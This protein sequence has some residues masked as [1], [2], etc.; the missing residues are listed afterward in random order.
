M[1]KELSGEG[2]HGTDERDEEEQRLRPE[3][4][5]HSSPFDEPASLT[6]EKPGDAAPLALA[7]RI[8]VVNRALPDEA[9]AGCR[10]SV[11]AVQGMT[12]RSGEAAL[13]LS[14]LSDGRFPLRVI[15]PDVYGGEI[16][17]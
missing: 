8:V 7:A 6:P 4:Q 16:G 2:A 12:T 10:V 17:P 3:P 11:G 14:R 15:A 1:Q 13:D 9:V 5:L